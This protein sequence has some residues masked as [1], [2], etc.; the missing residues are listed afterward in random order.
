MTRTRKPSTSYLLLGLTL[1][2]MLLIAAYGLQLIPLAT[3]PKPGWKPPRCSIKKQILSDRQTPTS[4]PAEFK[5]SDDTWVK[6]TGYEITDLKLFAGGGTPPK[7]G[8]KIRVRASGEWKK[9]EESWKLYIGMMAGSGSL[10]T[11]YN[12]RRAALDTGRS[13]GRFSRELEFTVPAP[14]PG[15]GAQYSVVHVAMYIIFYETVPS[16]PKWAPGRNGLVLH[17]AAEVP[18]VYFLD[19]VFMQQ[20][21]RHRFNLIF[22]ER[23]ENG[24]DPCDAVRYYAGDWPEPEIKVKSADLSSSPPQVSVVYRPRG[25]PVTESMNVGDLAKLRLIVRGPVPSK[26]YF[27]QGWG[28]KLVDTSIMVYGGEAS[29]TLDIRS[30]IYPGYYLVR[31]ERDWGGYIAYDEKIVKIGE[32]EEP[33]PPLVEKVEFKEFEVVKTFGKQ[34]YCKG[35]SETHAPFWCGVQAEWDIKA[36]IGLKD[37]QADYKVVYRVYADRLPQPSSWKTTEKTKEF[38]GT[39]NSNN[40][41]ADVS[42]SDRLVLKKMGFSNIINPDHPPGLDYVHI[43]VTLYQKHLGQYKPVQAKRVKIPLTVEKIP[44]QP[45]EIMNLE[46]EEGE[47]EPGKP[48]TSVGIGGDQPVKNTASYYGVGISSSEEAEVEIVHK[49]P[50]GKTERYRIPV[51]PHETKTIPVPLREK[52]RHTIAVKAYDRDGDLVNGRT[53]EVEAKQA[54]PLETIWESTIQIFTWLLDTLTSFFKSLFSRVLLSQE[55]IGVG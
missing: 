38:A 9:S 55:V 3:I 51:K 33:P 4:L 41:E 28:Y 5:Y 36:K 1:I 20:G 13:E 52:G 25:G 12:P 14:D 48:D 23:I 26:S 37:S 39:L 53:F 32:F 49:K 30:K 45:V 31:V 6:I 11:V 17:A 47:S 43:V 7:L 8:Y 10:N 21:D 29:K 44:V 16:V 46:P 35:I 40:P 18:S 24:V 42:W 27:D 15:H 54:S 34:L 50:S 19:K 2:I 22:G